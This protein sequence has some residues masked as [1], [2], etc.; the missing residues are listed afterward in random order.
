MKPARHEACLLLGSNILPEQHLPLAVER[1][2]KRVRILRTSSVWETTAV[3]S[4]GPNYLN[5]ALL[6]ESP[7]DFAALKEQVLRPLEAQLGRVRT[8]D[9]NAPRTMDIDILFFDG[10]AVDAL[11]WRYAFRAVPAAELLPAAI[12]ETGEKLKDVAARLAGSAQIRLRRDVAIT[13]IITTG[14]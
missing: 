10:H 13:E 1:L 2:Q 6:V 9:K 3:G 8:K 12:S 14:K 11:V 4:D 5:M 7:F